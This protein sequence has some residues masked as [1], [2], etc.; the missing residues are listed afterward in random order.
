MR[1]SKLLGLGRFRFK[2]GNL[3]DQPISFSLQLGFLCH[4]IVQLGFQRCL[5]SS[6]LRGDPYSF[7][8]F[9]VKKKEAKASKQDIRW[10]ETVLTPHVFELRG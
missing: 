4:K 2:P 3:V 1:F 9:C 5:V 6:S 10:V 7:E 8:E